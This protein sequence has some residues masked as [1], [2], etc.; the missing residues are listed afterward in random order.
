[1]A[2]FTPGPWAIKTDAYGRIKWHADKRNGGEYLEV[3]S[4]T[5]WVADIRQGKADARLIAAAP[6][7]YEMLDR[8]GED[9][10]WTPAFRNEVRALLAR[11]D[12]EDDGPT[13]T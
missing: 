3:G 4:S 7:M 1:M 9:W 6:E 5:V 8:M 10:D 2:K 13:H 11:I 12:G